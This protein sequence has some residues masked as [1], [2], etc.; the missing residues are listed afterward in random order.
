[1]NIIISNDHAGVELKNKVKDYLESKG[2][3]LKRL[4][5]QRW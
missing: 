4:W 5:K 3:K 2:Y 1:M